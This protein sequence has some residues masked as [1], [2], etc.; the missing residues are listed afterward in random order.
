MNISNETLQDTPV[1]SNWLVAPVS[2][3]SKFGDDIWDLEIKVAGQRAD[4]SIVKWQI[5]PSF[6]NE[7]TEHETKFL[8]ES[9]KHFVWSLVY[10]PPSGR[11]RI[12]ASTIKSKSMNLMTIIGWM[13]SQGLKQFKSIELTDIDAFKTWLFLRP[14]GR[15]RFKTELTPNTASLFF[16]ILKD[17]YR[18][19]Y[20]LEDSIII[21]PLPDETTY[22]AAGLT[23]ET[24]GSISFIPDEIS[25]PMLQNA[26]L[27][28]EEFGDMVKTAEEARLSIWLPIKKQR[29]HREARRQVARWLLKEE[30][31]SPYGGYFR[32]NYEIRKAVNYLM[33]ACYVVIAGFVG[34]RVSEILALK[35][36]AIS[37]RTLGASG[38]KQAFINST[39]FKTSPNSEG[40]PEMWVAPG[41]VVKAV[42]RLESVNQFLRLESGL[43]SLFLTRNTQREEIVLLTAQHLNDRVNSFAQQASLPL[44]NGKVWLFSSHQFRK[45]FARFVARK[46]RS[47]LLGLSQHFKHASVAMTARGYIGTD[48]DLHELIDEEGRKD[49]ARA[50]EGILSSNNLAGKMGERIV[51]KNAQ[52]RGRAGTQVRKDYIEFVMKETDLGIHACDYGWCVF[53]PETAKCDGDVAPNEVNRSP[54]ACLSCSNM[55]VEFKHKPYWDDRKSR[56]IALLA[57][58]NTLTTA[59]VNKVIAECDSVLSKLKADD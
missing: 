21:D 9:A 16:T 46:D 45:T 55:V 48:F 10:D 58:A 3:I 14:G 41:P 26:L 18:Q 54:T 42:E 40:Q 2:E 50:L 27:W 8:I 34:M 11:K 5:R 36:G 12:S 59:V 4:M 19:R 44:Y 24:K 49:T 30:V 56:N 25:I 29:G 53:Q 17:I 13:A 32:T 37:Y 28:V 15:G 39:L 23:R 57:E 52:F 33:S 20:K 51:S 1:S 38:S 22:E 7:L 35:V 47:Q 31:E 43:Q 6:K